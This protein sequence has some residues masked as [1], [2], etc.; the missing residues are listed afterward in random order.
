MGKVQNLP[1]TENNIGTRW[2][3]LNIFRETIKMQN[4]GLV[5][6]MGQWRIVRT[7]P[8]TEEEP[9]VLICFLPKGSCMR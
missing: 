1:E 7:A 4:Y 2:E 3:N 6:C 8:D 9:A 5:K